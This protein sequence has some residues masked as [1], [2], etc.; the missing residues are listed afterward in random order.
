[1]TALAAAIFVLAAGLAIAVA[2]RTLRCEAH[3]IAGLRQALSRDML[4]TNIRISVIDGP[5]PANFVMG[6]LASAARIPAIRF[7]R[8]APQQARMIAL[9]PTR[10]AA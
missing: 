2:W 5:Q 9:E 7:P 6:A 10:L 3:A 1:M 4:V 8:A